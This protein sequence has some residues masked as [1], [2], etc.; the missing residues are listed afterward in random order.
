MPII[1]TA[2]LRQGEPIAYARQAYNGLDCCVT[3][4]VFE[5]L[6]KLPG[7]GVRPNANETNS[8]YNFSRAL[9]APILEMMLRGWKVDEYARQ[10][11]IAELKLKLDRLYQILNQMAAA[12]WSRPPTKN[13]SGRLLNLNPR[14]QPQM[15]EFFY[16]TMGLD[17]IWTSKK[18]ER[19]LSMDREALEKLQVNFLAMPIIS[20]ILS[21]RAYEKQLSVLETEI[22]PDGR[23]RTSY[24]LTTETGRLS[25]SASSTGTGS[26]LQN[27]D[28]TLRYIFEADPDY[29]IAGFDLE[30]AESRDVG[31]LIGLLFNDWTYLDACESADLHTTT[32][33]MI[34]PALTAEKDLEDSNRKLICTKGTT[35]GDNAKIN[36][37]LA[38][39]IFYRHFSYRDMSKRGGHG[40]TYYGTAFTMARHLKVPVKFMEDFQKAFFG[41][42][43]GIAKWHLWVAQQIQTKQ[44]LTTPFGRTRHFFSRPND[45]AT[46][47]EAIAYSPQSSTADRTNLALWR[48]WH[49]M[50][51]QVKILHQNHD[52]VYFMYKAEDEAEIIPKAKALMEIETILPNGRKFVIPTDCAIGWNWGKHHDTGKPIGDNNRFNPNGL[53]KWKGPG[54][55]TR[56]RLTGL[57]R[58]F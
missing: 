24:N 8:V 10:T 7:A 42:Y 17:E 39:Q 43:P 58:P 35:W 15:I 5:E 32:A 45:D 6:A 50:G 20:T 16:K 57:D 48:I 56:K 36:R 23:I 41:A 12:V 40:T 27:I 13:A 21:I 52:A 47:R 26:N 2:K 34:W 55:D 19:K 29:K 49:Y 1:E 9:Q 37:A 46:L 53:I 14:S 31:M 44:Q 11:G 54:L 38:E 3:F 18:G 51:K 28:P 4:E 22:D 33:R 30:Q 25:S